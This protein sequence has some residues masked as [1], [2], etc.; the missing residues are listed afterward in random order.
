[1]VIPYKNGYVL[2]LWC[3]DG[4]VNAAHVQ[5]ALMCRTCASVCHTSYMH[6]MYATCVCDMCCCT[7]ACYMY[8]AQVS[9]AYMH[10]TT[11][12]RT[13]CITYN[14]IHLSINPMYLNAA[15]LLINECQSF[16][17]YTTRFISGINTKFSCVLHTQKLKYA[18]Y[19]HIPIYCIM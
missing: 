4:A 12:L 8:A 2:R 17:F 7:H 1:M 10:I 18:T 11:V 9:L 13:R 14:D 15:V 3:S 6:N 5:A 16:S 19:K